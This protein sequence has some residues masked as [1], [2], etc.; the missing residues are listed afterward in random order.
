MD[1]LTLVTKPSSDYELVDSGR[2]EKL[3]RYGTAGKGRKGNGRPK[4]IYLKSG[5]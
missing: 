2:E 3:E 1:R 5:K 4:Q